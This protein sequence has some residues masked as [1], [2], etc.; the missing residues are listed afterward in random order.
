VYCYSFAVTNGGDAKAS[1]IQCSVGDPPVS[2]LA[3]VNILRRSN[4]W[5]LFRYLLSFGFRRDCI[6]LRVALGFLSFLRC[7]LRSRK[8]G[9]VLPKLS[10]FIRRVCS[11]YAPMWGVLRTPLV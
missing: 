11:G 4:L 10:S 3:I 8:P 5:I 2:D 9:D 6:L 1:V 7:F